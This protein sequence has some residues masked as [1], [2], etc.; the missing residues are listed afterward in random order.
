MT[1]LLQTLGADVERALTDVHVPSYVIDRGGTIAWLNPAAEKIVGDARGRRFTDVVAP[2][3]RTRARET[4]ARKIVGKEKVTNAE[5]ELLAPDG[6]R[7]SV[8][9]SSVPLRDGRQVVGV[10][11]LLS[12]PPAPARPSRPHAKLTPRQRQVLR[13][14]AQGASTQQIADELHLSRET[15]RNHV[16]GLLQ[17]L[18]VHSRVEAVATARAEGILDD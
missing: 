5:V 10:F 11:G 2:G 4:F 9:V 1:R 3:D 6:H 8:E 15:V 13:M 14:L 18:D 7:L 16:R 17:A 12:R